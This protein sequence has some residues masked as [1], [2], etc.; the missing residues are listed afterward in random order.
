[1]VNLRSKEIFLPA[2][3]LSS[4]AYDQLYFAIR[5]GLGQKLLDNQAGFFILDDPFIK[6]DQKRLRQQLDM[7]LNFSKNGWQIIYF[8][9]KN[10]VRDYLENKVNNLITIKN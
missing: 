5:L 6:S 7:L 8:S 4:G 2:E 3:S 1:M 10:E 9:A